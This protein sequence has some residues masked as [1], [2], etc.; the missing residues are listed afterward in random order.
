MQVGRTAAVPSTRYEHVKGMVSGLLLRLVVG[1]STRLLRT[2]GQAKQPELVR[3]AM[4][5][6]ATKTARD[7]RTTEAPLR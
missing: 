7:C 3:I 1:T 5:G 6:R 4:E 2:G